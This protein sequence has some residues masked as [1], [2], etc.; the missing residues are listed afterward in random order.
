MGRQNSLPLLLPPVIW[1]VRR[2]R[3]FAMSELSYQDLEKT[4]EAYEQLL[5]PAIFEECANRLVDAA[6]IGSGQYV[7]DI[8]CGTGIA[9]RIVAERVA[10]DG[11]ATG[12]DI[13]PGMLAVARRI[14]S[15]IDWHEGSVDALPYENEAFDAVICQFGLMFFS[16]PERALREMARVLKTNGR[17]AVSTFESLDKQPAY[18]AVVDI[19][20][21]VINTSVGATARGPYTMGDTEK[22]ASIFSAAGITN[23]VITT[24]E[25]MLR[26]ASVRD[27]IQAEVRGWFPFAQILLDNEVIEEAV[28][29]AERVLEPFCASDGT[30]AAAMP[31]HIITATKP[32]ES[33]TV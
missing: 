27:L 21:R 24:Q 17:L 25:A 10:P 30:V 18:S 9:T 22:L 31:I 3:K 26:Y 23:A 29:E 13:N 2:Q 7:L 5:V 6:G 16:A 8:A 33:A 11:T 32:M 12:L 14:T 4:A 19:Y 20:D 15:E 28:R 1:D